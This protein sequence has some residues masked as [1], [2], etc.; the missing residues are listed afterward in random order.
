MYRYLLLAGLVLAGLAIALGC[1]S[2]P[3]APGAPGPNANPTTGG[4]TIHA[5]F[6]EA[7]ARLIPAAA[8]CIDLQVYNASTDEH[9]AGGLLTPDDPTVE[10]T[11]LPGGLEC[12]LE[13]AAYPDN[14][15]TE[16]SVAQAWGT[17]TETVVPGVLTPIT[18]TMESTITDVVI[19]PL[20]LTLYLGD[21]VGLVAIAMNA[22]GEFVLV[23]NTWEWGTL[24]S[25]SPAEIIDD[26]VPNDDLATIEA[27]FEGTATITVRETESGVEAQGEVE[28]LTATTGTVTGTVYGPDGVTP[29]PN[30]WV[31]VPDEGSSAS[32]R[33]G[34]GPPEPW[35]VWTLTDDNGDF[36]LEDVP[37][38]LVLIKILKGSW[39]KTFEADVP[40]GGVYEA[41]ADET[42]FPSSGD[43]LPRIAVV[44]GAWDHMQDVLAKLGLGEV[45]ESGQLVPGTEQFDLIDWADTAAFFGDA[46]RLFEYDIIFV[47]CGAD[48]SILSDPDAT[49]TANIQ[50]YVGSGRSL[51]VTDLAY[52]YVEQA[53][54]EAIQFYGDSGSTPGPLNRAQVGDG[55]ITT[56]AT[57]NDPTMHAWLDSQGALN[58]DGTVHISGFLGGWAL[59]LETSAGATTWIEGNVSWTDWWLGSSSS[60][61]GH[62]SPPVTASQVGESGYLPLTVTFEYGSGR[63]LY[64][65]YHTEDE[66]SPDLR[67]QERILGY[68]VFEM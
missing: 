16:D 17:V 61:N 34:D 39:T 49:Y 27:M 57:V 3:G 68:L 43:E 51:Y 2:T 21:R 65:S 9:L 30:A 52:D 47:N 19:D 67:P 36:V 4:F 25:P 26:G 23:G 56:D 32:V 8:Q 22:D 20:P 13:A 12:R 18:L 28:V 53:F 42:T 40:A 33:Q 66:P 50:D 45:D 59:M 58:T 10:V 5:K 24:D 14:P 37:A 38:G 41:S 31:F 48:E 46:E 7:S 63:V 54:P 35:I 11:G 55:G 60:R 1:S 62:V 6:P 15:P 29:I 64:S 44:V